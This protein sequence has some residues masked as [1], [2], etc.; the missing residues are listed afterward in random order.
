MENYNSDC[1][2]FNARNSRQTVCHIPYSD[3]TAS[4]VDTRFWTTAAIDNEGISLLSLHDSIDFPPHTALNTTPT[5]PQSAVSV[6][7][8]AVNRDYEV[9]RE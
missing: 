3:S 8:D 7:G 2:R 4:P 1:V 6:V 5:N 9:P